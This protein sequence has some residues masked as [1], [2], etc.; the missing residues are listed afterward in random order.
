MSGG[1]TIIVEYDLSGIER[2]LGDAGL[3]A[4]QSA[5]GRRVMEDSNYFVMYD[6]GA[7]SRSAAVA[8]A[9]DEV[10]WSTPY[11][12]EAYNSGHARTVKN[13][14]A[15]PRWFEYAKSVRLGEWEKYVGSLF[16]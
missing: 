3:R 16:R 6:T 15:H 13:P 4:A 1:I 12:S 5:F 10:S 14:N 2:K 9:G 11:A 7:T 8:T